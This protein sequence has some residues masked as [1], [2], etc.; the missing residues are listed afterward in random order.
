MP[1]HGYAIKYADLVALSFHPVK[2]I[3]EGAFL[4]RATI[5]CKGSRMQNSW[6]WYYEMRH[7]EI[8]IECQSL[9]VF[10]NFVK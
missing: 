4:Q 10:H 5:S 6:S 7:L 3:I 2:N 1:C 8:I 9:L